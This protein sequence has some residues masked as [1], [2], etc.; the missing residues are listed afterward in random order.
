MDKPHNKVSVI[1]IDPTPIGKIWLAYS[2]GGL[3]AVNVGGSKENLIK[4][5]PPK[6]EISPVILHE[7]IHQ[8]ATQIKEYME[9]KREAFDLLIDWSG[10]TDFQRVVLGAVYAIPYGETRS[11]GQIAAQIGK[12]KASRAVGRA[13]A[14]NPIPLVIPCHRVIGADGHLRGYGAGEG[15][16]TK[17]WLLDMEKRFS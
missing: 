15:I 2:S 11:Y 3:A 17:A 4:D 16:K 1:V 8:A 12:P 7:G 14:T 13:N 10:A 5:I 6:Y 9:G